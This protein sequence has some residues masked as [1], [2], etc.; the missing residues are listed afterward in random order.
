MQEEQIKLPFQIQSEE[1]MVIISVG[2]RLNENL[3]VCKEYRK[4]GFR[5]CARLAFR[6]RIVGSC[7]RDE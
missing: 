5:D 2:G 1:T 7:K 6:S 4:P 3:E